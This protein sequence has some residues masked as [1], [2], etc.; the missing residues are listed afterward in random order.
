MHQPTGSVGTIYEVQRKIGNA[1]FQF[2][3][4]IGVK[5]FLDETLPTGS[6]PVTYKITAVRSTA[7]GNSAQFTVNFGVGGQTITLVEGG[8]D[9]KMA[10]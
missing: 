9:L 6:A 2:I 4:G 7:R 8:S 10:A 1:G 5:T 3:G